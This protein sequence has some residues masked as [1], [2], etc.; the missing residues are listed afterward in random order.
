M[1]FGKRYSQKEL[2]EIGL[3]FLENTDIDDIAKLHK[4]HPT[5]WTLIVSQIADEDIYK[6]VNSKLRVKMPND[7]EVVKTLS[8][9]VS[10]DY[11]TLQ[12]FASKQKYGI[13]MLR[14]MRN[15][16][17]NIDEKLAE[18]VN[19]KIKH[20]MHS[21]KT[22]LKFEIENVETMNVYEAPQSDKDLEID[23]WKEKC[24]AI[25]NEY[26]FYEEVTEEKLNKLQSQYDYALKT[27]AEQ[28]AEIERL[29]TK[30]TKQV[31]AVI[32]RK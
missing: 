5:S 27:I 9:F 12:D 11:T 30:R 28:T 32:K 13:Q 21:I 4:F 7:S 26:K 2:N 14:R 1:N 31:T 19:K 17:N 3:A 29:K 22:S 25:E 6:A 15:R 24:K 16:I 8:E 20:N 10:G 23:V 18:M